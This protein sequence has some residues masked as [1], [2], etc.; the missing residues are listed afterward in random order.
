MKSQEIARI[1]QQN[2]NKVE[3]KAI[4]L[5]MFKNGHMKAKL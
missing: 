4:Q 5:T 1:K 2:K 3:I